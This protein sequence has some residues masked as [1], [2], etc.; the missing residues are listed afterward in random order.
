MITGKFSFILIPRQLK[1]I[2][3]CINLN[4]I[5]NSTSATIHTHSSCPD[6]QRAAVKVW[7]DEAEATGT[8]P[9]NQL[10][11]SRMGQFPKPI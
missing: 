1:S 5:G 7:F 9:V 2:I 6:R 10:L 8:S 4:S 3:R 11:R